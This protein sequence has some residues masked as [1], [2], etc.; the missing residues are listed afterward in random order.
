MAPSLTR[1]DASRR[2]ALGARDERQVA[3]DRW[4]G[5]GVTLVCVSLA[6]PGAAK[7]PP[8]ALALYAWAVDQLR[9][10]LPAARRVY[11]T[12]D[13]L[14]PFDLWT[15]PGDASIVKRRCIA[16]EASVP[17]ARLVDLD[18]FS[19]EGIAIDRHALQ[20]PPRPCLCC[21]EPARDCMRAGRHAPEDVVAH[22]LDLLTTFRA[23]PARPF[24]GGRPLA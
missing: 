22:A 11:L 4:R 13:A 12:K 20:L 16:V 21:G 9:S 1:F 19:P 14:G 17:A 7:T 6:I 10:A 18:V 24:P 15:T 23:G 2:E 5:V 8:G 3:L